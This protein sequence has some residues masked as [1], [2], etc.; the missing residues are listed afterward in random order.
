MEWL[1]RAA[2]RNH[3]EAKKLLDLVRTSSKGYDEPI[4]AVCRLFNKETDD[5]R[6]MKPYS[7]LLG[8]A[9]RSMIEVKEEKDLDEMKQMRD[10]AAP[11]QVVDLGR[12]DWWFP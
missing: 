4:A 9:I 8:S 2:A 12:D 1:K 10:L 5:G 3:T 11:R 7:D 6:N